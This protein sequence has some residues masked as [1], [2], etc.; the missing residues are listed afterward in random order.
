MSGTMILKIRDIFDETVT[1]GYDGLKNEI[2]T[3]QAVSIR[4]SCAGL[5]REELLGLK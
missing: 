4:T 5:R 3:N 2:T 1:S